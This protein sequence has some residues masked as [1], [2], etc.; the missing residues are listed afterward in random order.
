[1]SLLGKRNTTLVTVQAGFLRCSYLKNCGM[2]TESWHFLSQTIRD[3]QEI[4]LHRPNQ[5]SRPR[6]PEEV[7]ENLWI[8]QLRR[9]V[10]VLLTVWDVRMA[11]TLGRPTTIDFRNPTSPY[12]IDAPVPKHRHEVAP[13]PRSPSD[14][15]TPLTVLL[16]NAELASPLWDIHV[17]EKEPLP[18][19]FA[20]VERMHRLLNH[21]NKQCP[22]YFRSQN[23][24]T[25]FDS[26]PDCD[27]LPRTRAN[28]QTL[29]A[30]NVMA[31]HRPY[32]FMQASS[33][34]AAL[35][36]A[37]DILRSQRT[38]FELIDVKDYKMHS[39]VMSTFDALI[40]A[41]AI[42][43]VHPLENRYDLDET[44]QHFEW[45]MKRVETI[46]FRNS[47]ARSALSILKA[48]Y[49]RLTKA[50]ASKRSASQPFPTPSETPL[51]HKSDASPQKI[52]PLEP[53]T[54]S[55]YPPPPIGNASSTPIPP[56]N[57]SMVNIP[58][59]LQRMETSA[60]WE[61]FTDTEPSLPQNYTSNP[62]N[63]D[64]TNMAP[65]QPFHDLLYYDLSTFGNGYPQNT[66]QDLTSAPG[67]NDLSQTNG[68]AVQA[69][70]TSAAAWQFEGAFPSDSFWGVLNQYNP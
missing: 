70:D 62:Q 31:L 24:D 40:L 45:G 60:S 37:L 39:L 42:Y 49:V 9:R 64:F 11:L 12:L 27:W 32:I 1:M 69:L 16:W 20:K 6:K 63:F 51:V 48:I 13:A 33:R 46:V 34:T 66:A 53:T 61:A 17:L 26:H 21:V 18:V 8:E 55:S 25:T 10:W 28:F 23:P 7:V 22:A 58:E 50:V 68:P 36:A 29:A 57:L 67:W 41:A 65:L 19:D 35:K 38:L 2:V 44:L 54:E 15:P 59:S 30:F 56:Y 14:P 52:H 5:D 4:D 43:I 3:A 47:M